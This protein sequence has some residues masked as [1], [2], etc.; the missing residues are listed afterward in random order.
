[1]IAIHKYMQPPFV[2][3]A[4]FEASRLFLSIKN[5][6]FYVIFI[7][8]KQSFLCHKYINKYHIS[9]I[10]LPQ[11]QPA[12]IKI[13]ARYLLGLNLHVLS[14]MRVQY[15]IKKQLLR[16]RLQPVKM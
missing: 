13:Q 4:G 12:Q 16:V 6:V 14:K 15:N 5:R 9:F 1:M 8:K 11:A 2:L 7:Y 10:F 3:S